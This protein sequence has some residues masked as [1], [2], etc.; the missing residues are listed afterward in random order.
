MQKVDLNL[1]RELYD[2]A[3]QHKAKYIAK[4]GLN[5]EIVRLISKTKN[6]PQWLLEKRLKALELFTKT[7]VPNWGPDLSD[8]DVNEIVF[9]VDPNAKET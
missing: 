2:K 8:L 9:F 4:P 6:E 3:D 7:P 5:E 1:N